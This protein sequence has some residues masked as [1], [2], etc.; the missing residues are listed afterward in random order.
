[1]TAHYHPDADVSFRAVYPIHRACTSDC[2]FRLL[3][4]ELE[5]LQVLAEDGLLNMDDAWLTVT[6]K[7]RL[8]IRNI[9]MVFDRYLNASS[10][11]DAGRARYSRTI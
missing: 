11:N 3:C 4:P 6:P 5:K 2:F 1:M 8:L 10:K 9:C 7:G